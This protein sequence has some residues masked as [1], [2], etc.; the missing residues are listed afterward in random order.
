MP[1][2]P[3]HE[4]KN[5]L[6]AL[7]REA[8]TGK[9]FIL[10]D[11]KRK[12]DKPVSLISTA[13]LDELC[14]TKTFSLEWIDEP[15]EETEHYSLYNQETGVYGV[16]PTKRE[17]IEDFINNIVN[18]TEVYSNDLP[19]YLSPSGGRREHYWYLRRSIRCKGDKDQIYLVLDLNKVLE[20]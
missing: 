5:K 17:A 11:A 15:T 19:F 20:G 6:S 12:D 8:I 14:E 7:R 2:V 16:G 18:Y 1:S 13:L 3:I 10:A 4:A 9:E